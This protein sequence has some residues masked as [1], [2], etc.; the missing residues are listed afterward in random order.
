MVAVYTFPVDRAGHPLAELQSSRP[1]GVKE[2]E[3]ASSMQP[4]DFVGI[5]EGCPVEPNLEG[6]DP[7]GRVPPSIN[8]DDHTPTEPESD[9]LGEAVLLE[10]DTTG[11][12]GEAEESVGAGAEDRGKE[13][14]A[15]CQT[16]VEEAQNVAVR[17]LTFVETLPGRAVGHILPALARIYA[18]LRSLGLPVY[19]LH[20]DRARELISAPVRRWTLDRGIVTTLTSGDSFKSNGLVEGELGV[21]KKHVRTVVT[22]VNMGLDIWPLAAIHIGERRLRSQLRSMCFPVGPLLHFGARAYA[23]KKSWQ[24]R[25]QPWRDIRDEVRVLGPAGTVVSA[26]HQLLCSVAGDRQ[27]LLYR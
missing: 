13:A 12:P 8:M 22:S 23:L 9:D 19:R 20:C 24:D 26:H 2:A 25:Y 11:G 18:R 4:P 10:E 27:V 1:D 6:E 15:A 7:D 3:P 21:I 17:N 16:R 14:F 5:P